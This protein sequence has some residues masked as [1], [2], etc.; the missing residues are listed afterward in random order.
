MTGVK[1]EINEGKVVR[2]YTIAQQGAHGRGPSPPPPAVPL[3]H[4]TTQEWA[5]GPEV[6]TH[7]NHG[8]L[9]AAAQDSPSL[10]LG[11]RRRC[12]SPLSNRLVCLS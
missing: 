8:P 11:D 6:R 10:A 12:I 7:L 4:P 1:W 2:F 5:T 9:E 3:H